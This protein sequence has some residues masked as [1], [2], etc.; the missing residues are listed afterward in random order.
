MLPLPAKVKC[1]AIGGTTGKQSGDLQDRLLGDGLVPLASALGEHDD[2]TLSLG[3][4]L[5]RKATLLA[6]NHMQ[7]LSAAPAYEAVKTFLT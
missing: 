4:P 2:P 5:H 6:T 1:F 7:L 3:F